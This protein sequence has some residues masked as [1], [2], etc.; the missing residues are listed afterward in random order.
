MTRN[1]FTI[2]EDRL[3][4]RLL[5]RPGVQSG[6]KDIYKKIS[7]KYGR[8]TFESWYNSFT[9]LVRPHLVLAKCFYGDDKYKNQ[10]SVAR[11]RRF[12]LFDVF[13]LFWKV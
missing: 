8:H 7:D 5:N 6:G 10:T 1:D 11:P 12:N 3:L 4:I 9:K 13:D 2:D